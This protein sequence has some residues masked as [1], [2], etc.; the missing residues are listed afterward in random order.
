M[1][2]RETQFQWGNLHKRRY[3]LDGKR[4]AESH[5]NRILKHH[6]YE[7]TDSGKDSNGNWF[8]VWNIGPRDDML[9]LMDTG[10]MI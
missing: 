2:L 1:I 3:F 6:M 10:D 4:I 5:A 7:Q 9:S 8:T